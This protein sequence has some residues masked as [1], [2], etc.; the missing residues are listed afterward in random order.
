MLNPRYTVTDK[1]L[2]NLTTIVFAREVIEQACLMSELEA[3]LRHRALLHNAH[4][5]T[6]ISGN[7]LSLSE[8][9]SLYKKKLEGL[10][11]LDNTS[12]I[13]YAFSGR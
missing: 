3:K 6:A 8:V 9:E 1:I 4:S 13:L 12:Y 5:S 7:K 11:I 2:N 10:K